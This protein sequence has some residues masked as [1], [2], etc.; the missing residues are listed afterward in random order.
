M[1]TMTY[2]G[3]KLQYCAVIEDYDDY[4]SEFVFTQLSVDGHAVNVQDWDA[5]K[6][7][8]ATDNLDKSLNAIR[9]INTKIA[10]ARARA[11]VKG[12]TKRPAAYLESWIRQ[13]R[14]NRIGQ[15]IGFRFNAKDAPRI[16]E[17]MD[18]ALTELGL[19]SDRDNPRLW[20][21][22]HRAA[23]QIEWYFERS[24]RLFGTWLWTAIMVA[25]GIENPQQLTQAP[26]T[27]D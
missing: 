8:L 3:K 18:Q 17:M 15:D 2:N 14:T 10:I 24:S 7:A 9:K 11:R 22:C 20:G 19:D 27:T 26:E 5:L 21:A 13:Q 23:N 4:G 6:R 1:N 12:L 25:Y 16:V